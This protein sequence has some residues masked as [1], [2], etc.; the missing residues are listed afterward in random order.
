[1]AQRFREGGKAYTKDGRVYVVETVEAGMVYCSAPGG[2]EAEFPQAALFNE[3]EWAAQSDGRRDAGYAQIHQAKVYRTAA[4]AVFDPDSAARVLTQS[5]RLIPGLLDYVAFTIG[6]RVL[7]EGNPELVAGLS[8][9]KCRKIF[10]EVPVRNRFAALAEVLA[11]PGDKLLGAA[12]L[13]DGMA[14][15][16]LEGGMAPY[17]AAFEDF[18]DRPRR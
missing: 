12:A 9:V 10:D 2:G 6:T 1:M 17:A 8:I 4:A 13:G 16:M 5:D 18:C 15:A 11:L 3:Q 7:A 14:K